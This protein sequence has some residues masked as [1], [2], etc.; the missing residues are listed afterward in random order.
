MPAAKARL[1]PALWGVF[2]LIDAV[3]VLGVL[4]AIFWVAPTPPAFATGQTMA[5]AQAANPSGLSVVLVTADHCLACQ[6]YKR[7][8]LADARVNQW[9]TENAG[10]VSLKWGKDQEQID[11]LHITSYP[12]TVLLINGQTLASQT[13]GMSAD[14]LLQFLQSNAQRATQTQD[15]T[16]AEAPA[17]P[18]DG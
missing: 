6:M 15:H 18:S 1:S 4:A 13:G 10:A 14:D 11:A 12:A 3:I 16:P 7:G 5:Q 9:I 17:A 8:A 2:I